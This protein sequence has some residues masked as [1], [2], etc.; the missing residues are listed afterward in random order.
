MTTVACGACGE[1]Y[2]T[3]REPVRPGADTDRCPACGN[4]D[5]VSPDAT[6]GAGAGETMSLT[7]QRGATVRITIEV[8]PPTDD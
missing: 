8:V 4:A 7:A 5:P 1:Q 6:P 2:D 3:D